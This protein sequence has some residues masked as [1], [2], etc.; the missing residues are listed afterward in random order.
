MKGSHLFGYQDQREWH[1]D[2]GLLSA[3]VFPVENL[4]QG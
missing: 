1:L 3:K 2:Q 4:W